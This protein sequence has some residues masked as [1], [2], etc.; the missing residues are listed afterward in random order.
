MTLSPTLAKIAHIVLAVLVLVSSLGPVLAQF[1][2]LVPATWLSIASHVV[3]LAGAIV[4][5]LSQ[6]PLTKP[7]LQTRRPEVTS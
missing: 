1:A 5:W 6:S 3:A 4:L 7:L 2:G